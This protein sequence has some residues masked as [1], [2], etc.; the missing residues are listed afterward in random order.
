MQNFRA[1]V[2]TF[3]K[4]S[5]VDKWKIN[6]FARILDKIENNAKKVEEYL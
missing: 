4:Y 6:V 3:K 5:D 2:S 1:A